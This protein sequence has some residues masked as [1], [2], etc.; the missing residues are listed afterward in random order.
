MKKAMESEEH[1]NKKAMKNGG[2]CSRVIKVIE[3]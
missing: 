1:E 2:Q 3:T